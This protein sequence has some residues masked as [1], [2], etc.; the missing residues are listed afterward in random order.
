VTTLVL[1]LIP[2]A[3]IITLPATAI[4]RRLGRR[5]GAMDAQ[6]TQGHVKSEVRR[7]PNTGGIAVFLGIFLPMGLG[8]AAVLLYGHTRPELEEVMPYI[9]DRVPMTIALLLGML[10]L[11]IMGVVDDRR[12]LGPMLKLG[13]QII[14]AGVLILGFDCRLLTMLDG[15]VGGPWLSYL[16]T[17]AWFIVVTNAINFMDNMDGLAGG[18]VAISASL[19]LVAALLNHQWLIGAVLALIVGS[20]LGFLVFNRPPASIF[21]GDGGSLVLGFLLAFLTVRTTYFGAGPADGPG[22][23]GGWYA[24][25]MPII[26]LAV[27]LYDFIGV[28]GLRLS[29]GRNPMVGDEQHFSHR[30]V[31]QGM[32][33]PAAVMVIYACALATGVGG[34]MLGRLAAWQA[35]LVFAQTACVLLVLAAFEF[36]TRGGNGR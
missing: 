6:G 8:L 23:G 24:V 19:F 15:A 35:I 5:L 17:L 11:H 20:C 28:V 16:L 9:R 30:L 34:I 33:R 12:P 14:V 27:P 21:M 32:S 26:V 31:R 25:F 3:L 1:I 22:L 18:V 4:M 10:L 7:V 29:Q 13:V 36:A 2:V